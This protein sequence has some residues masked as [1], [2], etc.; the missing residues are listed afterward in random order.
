MLET[1]FTFPL[2]NSDA[3][4][5]IMNVVPTSSPIHKRRKKNWN[6]CQP[7]MQWKVE[8]SEEKK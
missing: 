6:R 4:T 7:G 5:M 2:F 1:D 3:T 8:R